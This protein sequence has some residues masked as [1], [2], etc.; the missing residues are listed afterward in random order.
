MS[1]I[2]RAMKNMALDMFSMVKGFL[3]G[4][5]MVGLVILLLG[6]VIYGVLYIRNFLI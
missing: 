5:I 6:G 3:Y 1:F 4:F 2:L